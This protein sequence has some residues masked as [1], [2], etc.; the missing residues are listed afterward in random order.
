MKGFR[1]RD[2]DGSVPRPAA[3]ASTTATDAGVES[4]R[5]AT[6]QGLSPVHNRPEPRGGGKYRPALG[7][8]AQLFPLPFWA[9]MQTLAQIHRCRHLPGDRSNHPPVSQSQLLHSGI[10]GSGFR[11]SRRYPGLDLKSLSDP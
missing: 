11:R 4:S 3:R 8:P 5:A 7:N 10:V 2:A 9:E 6:G 1:E